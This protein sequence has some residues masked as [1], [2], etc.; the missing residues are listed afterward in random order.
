MK[1]ILSRKGFDSSNGAQPNPIMPDK[2]L[3]SL[4]IPY[5]N[6]LKYSVPSIR[7][8]SYFDI[9]K[10]LKSKT[11]ID[12]NSYCHLDPDIRY[13][14]IKRNNNW[15]GLFGQS[16]AAQ[17]HLMNQ[18]VGK[19]D[20][21]LFFGWFKEAEIVK[22]QLRYVRNAKDLHVI[23]GY[24][25]IGKMFTKPT[26]IISDIEVHPHA[27]FNEGN[28]CIYEATDYLSFNNSK[29]GY[30]TFTFR[31]NLVLTKRGKSRSRW[32]LPDIFKEVKISYHSENSFKNDYFDSAKIGQEFVLEANDKISDWVKNIIE[33]E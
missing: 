16:G 15:K 7:G 1:I 17:T 11:K 24:L 9:I 27:L 12:E 4:P 6:G 25:Q 32:N 2:T 19:N 3:V 28:D 8:R 33:N 13:D 26:S 18:G 10:Q 14:T 31:N 5:G 21:F 22:N 29:A 23:Y 30:G 20:I